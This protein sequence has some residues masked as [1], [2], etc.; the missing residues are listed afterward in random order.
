MKKTI[1]LSSRQ[2]KDVKGG[3]GCH[4]L[5][6]FGSRIADGGGSGSGHC[7]VDG[8]TIFECICTNDQQCKN[9][10]GPNA[11]CWV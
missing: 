5:T 4:S 10:Y 6:H 11:S 1:E 8:E 7:Y 2:M 3:G 9:I